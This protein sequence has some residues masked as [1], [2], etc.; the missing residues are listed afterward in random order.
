MDDIEYLRIARAIEYLDEQHP[1][2]PPLDEVAAVLGVSPSYLQRVFR[3]LTGIS[4]K[5]FLQYLTLDYARRQLDECR[6]VG[7]VTS[8]V[9]LSSAGRLHDLFVS[10]EA[11]TPGEYGARGAGLT[12]AYGFHDTRFGRCL[13]GAT[14]RGICALSFH[15]ADDGAELGRF[16]ARWSA[17]ERVLDPARTEPFIARIFA[18]GT[19]GVPVHLRGTN[20]QLKVWEALLRVPPGH[21]TTYGALAAGLGMP[22]GARAVGAAVGANPIG[23]LIPCHR[24]IRELGIPGE[25]RW[26][27]PRKR[28]LLACEAAA[29]ER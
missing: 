1:R 2:H 27:R 14:D 21:V 15:T 20:F 17:A 7:E 25:Y 8:A 11:V 9:G 4:P 5:R 23:L 29:L 19:E 13:V 3:R 26:G 10:A 24:V 6:S 18:P 22:T 16:D 12:I 28:L